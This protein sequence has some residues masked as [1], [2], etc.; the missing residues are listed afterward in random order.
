MPFPH[1]VISV[2]AASKRRLSPL[3]GPYTPDEYHLLDRVV[4]QLTKDGRIAYAYVNEDEKR[5]DEITVF[6]KTSGE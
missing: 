5:P 4:K 6:R 3:A 2:E 1:K